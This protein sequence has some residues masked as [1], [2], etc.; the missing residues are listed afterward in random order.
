MRTAAQRINAYNDRM[1][2]SQIDPTIAAKNVQ[3]KGNFADYANDWYP[4]QVL[5]HQ[6]LDSTGVTPAS[7]FNYDGF[8]GEVYHVSNHFSGASAVLAV[9]D[10]IIKWK[11]FGTVEAQLKGIAAIFSI[12]IP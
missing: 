1:V 9:A 6:Y 4:K 11:L 8:A 5:V 12:V 2:S 10:L 7:Y 3:Q